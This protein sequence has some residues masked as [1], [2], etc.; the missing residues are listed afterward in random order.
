MKFDIE[1]LRRFKPKT[2]MAKMLTFTLGT[3][4][5]LGFVKY[6]QVSAEMRGHANFQP[7]PEA[8]TSAVVAEMPWKDSVEV[9]GSLTAT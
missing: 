8:I 6:L 5:I 4:F 9:V 3:L 2:P 7:P 1:K